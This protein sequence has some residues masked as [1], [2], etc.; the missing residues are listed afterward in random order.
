MGV[1]SAAFMKCYSFHQ[2]Q[3]VA[4]SAAQ[5]WA[6]F[7]QPANLGRLMP[8]EMRMRHP[9]GEQEGPVFAGQV[10]WFEVELFPLVWKRWVTQ[11]TQVEPGVSFIDEQLSGPY[12]FWRHRHLITPLTAQSCRITDAVIYALPFPPFGDLFHTLLVRP[13]LERIFAHRK[14]ALERLQKAGISEIDC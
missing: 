9:G 7:S 3:E 5:A 1:S 2:E 8:Q 4:W 6:F 13:Q 10:L 14:L 11:I 12:R